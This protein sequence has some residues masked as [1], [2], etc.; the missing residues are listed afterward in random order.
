MT[1]PQL[2]GIYEAKVVTA[3]S[4]TLSVLVPQV[5]RDQ[6]VPVNRWVGTQPVASAMGFVAFIGGDPAWPV[7][8]G[9]SNVPVTS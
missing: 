1:P 6:Q 5:F 9:Q 4:G 8:L 7:W 3:A 2:P